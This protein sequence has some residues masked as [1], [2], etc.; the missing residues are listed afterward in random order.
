MAIKKT[1][2]EAPVFYCRS[3]TELRFVLF[4]A[5]LANCTFIRARMR[6]ASS[7]KQGR[8]TE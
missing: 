8:R 7:L 1:G 5:Q 2:A 4:M 6:V 3:H